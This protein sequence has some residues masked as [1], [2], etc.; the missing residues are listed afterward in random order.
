[1][2][3]EVLIKAVWL[4]IPTCSIGYCWWE[5]G[6]NGYCTCRR[7]SEIAQ[8]KYKKVWALDELSHAQVLD[9]LSHA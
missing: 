2:Q 7:W 9:E 5:D 4:P 6:D 1:M 3:H 8:T